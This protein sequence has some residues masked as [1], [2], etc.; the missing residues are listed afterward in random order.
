MSFSFDVADAFAV[1]SFRV[2]K[3]DLESNLI[4][5]EIECGAGERAVGI[6]V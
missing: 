5:F 3:L 1:L 2:G 6:D 4:H